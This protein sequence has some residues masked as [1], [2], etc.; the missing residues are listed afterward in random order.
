MVTPKG[1]A[2]LIDFGA[3]KYVSVTDESRSLRSS[4][5][6]TPGYAPV[7]QLSGVRE[8]MGPWTDFYAL[9]ATLFNM[10]TGERPANPSVIISD[11]SSDKRN[12]IPLPSSLSERMRRL[13][14]WMMS[15]DQID[16]PQ[17]VE[18]ILAFLNQGMTENEESPKVEVEQLK[19]SENP[20]PSDD[21][22]VIPEEDIE[23][24]VVSIEGKE[25]I[26][27]ESEDHKEPDGAEI[28]DDSDGEEISNKIDVSDKA[29]LSEESD[30]VDGSNKSDRQE[31]TDNSD[32][33]DKQ[34]TS[35][36]V[37][38]LKTSGKQS[39]PNK[40]DGLYKSDKSDKSVNQNKSTDSNKSKNSNN[41]NGSYNPIWPDKPSIQE[42]PEIL[43]NSNEETSSYKWLKPVG[44]A[45]I[46]LVLL[47]GWWM[48]SDAEATE[49]ERILQNLV[50]NMVSVEGGT[51]LL[52]ATAEQGD[53]AWDNEKP[54]HQVTV[55]SFS[56]G[57]Y[58]VTQE[59]WEAVMGENPSF[60]K[61]D[62]KRPVESVTWD[63][64]KKFIRKLNKLTGKKFRLPNEAE[65]EFAARGGNKN[66]EQTK[67][68]G[69]TDIDAVAWHYDNSGDTTHPVGEKSPN[70]L[71][72]YDM[73]GNVREWC[74]D[75]YGPYDSSTQNDPKGP[76]S[77]LDRVVRG[78]HFNNSANYCRVSYRNFWY[79][80]DGGCNNGFRLAQ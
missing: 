39:S 55:S 47:L 69:G 9:G 32:K 21:S 40:S 30:K 27:L 53:D 70:A 26:P 65:W 73:S 18:E 56:I 61:G 44:I 29:V 79:P 20:V 14:L 49:K 17:T 74:E 78:G 80:S 8:D 62:K 19:P 63:D 57:K 13:V 28:S 15:P 48:I 52:G 50:D 43:D 66:L 75:Y 4:I 67:Y 34:D 51:F 46:A 6:Y 64:C 7:E 37:D 23:V 54:A 33:S 16:R 12:S 10:L 72:L 1:K 2:M 45:A 76:A 68:A 22:E 77:G 5:A 3:S 58:E 31:P 71:G 11:R 38:G 60:F 36:K 41:S 35:K 25:E 24:E 59:E 42:E